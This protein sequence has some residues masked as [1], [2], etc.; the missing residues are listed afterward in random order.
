MK[1]KKYNT[2]VAMST[3]KSKMAEYRFARSEEIVVDQ[4]KVNA[5]KQKHD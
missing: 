5:K 2:K 1:V 4:R 3:A